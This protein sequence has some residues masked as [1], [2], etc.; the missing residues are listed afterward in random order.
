MISGYVINLK[1]QIMLLQDLRK[2][3]LYALVTVRMQ[4]ICIILLHG[5]EK[6]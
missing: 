4:S 2:N 5:T 6:T 1:N 3:L